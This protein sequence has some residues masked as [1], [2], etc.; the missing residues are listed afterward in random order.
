MVLQCIIVV[1]LTARQMPR[2][3]TGV[4][5]MHLVRWE[6]L[7]LLSSK[8][9]IQNPRACPGFEPGTSRTRSANHTPR[10]TS[11][12]TLHANVSRR[13]FTPAYDVDFGSAISAR[14][15]PGPHVQ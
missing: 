10:P 15:S 4:S 9:A 1:E 3:D 2:P 12:L 6:P 5:S 14:N 13:N 8:V 11:Q 7:P